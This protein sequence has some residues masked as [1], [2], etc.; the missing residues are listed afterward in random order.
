[1]SWNIGTSAARLRIF[2]SSYLQTDIV[3]VASRHFSTCDLVSA[4]VNGNERHPPPSEC[5]C[6]PP[7]LLR[8]PQ[9]CRITSVESRTPQ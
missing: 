8:E 7:S 3:P 1:M 6:P 9:C 2:K 4:A 5:F